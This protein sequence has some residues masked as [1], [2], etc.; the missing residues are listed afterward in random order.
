MTLKFVKGTIVELHDNYGV[1]VTSSYKHGDEYIPFEITADMTIEKEDRRFIKYTEEVEF[2]LTNSYLRGRSI[3]EGK[4]VRFV[5]SE[6]K[7]QEMNSRRDYHEVVKQVFDAYCFKVP[8]TDKESDFQNYLTMIGFQPRMLDYLLCGGIFLSRK[9][10]EQLS[11]ILTHLMDFDEFKFDPKLIVAIDRIDSEF[12]AKIVKWITSFEDAIRMYICRS[13]GP[14]SNRKT[15]EE[16]LKLL[17]SRPVTAKRVA[18]AKDKRKFRFSSNI[19]EHRNGTVVPMMDVV[20]QMNLVDLPML[21]GDLSRI[22]KELGS[23]DSLLRLIKNTSQMIRDLSVLRNAAAHCRPILSSYMDPDYNGN[24]D[25]EFDNPS[26]RAKIEKWLL[27]SSLKEMWKLR[28]DSDVVDCILSTV[29]GNPL[30]K[31]WIELN[32]LYCAVVRFSDRSLYEQFKLEVL[33]FLNYPIDGDRANNKVKL[34]H[35]RMYDMGPTT[36]EYLSGVPAPYNV[37]ANEAFDIWRI[38]DDVE[39]VD[40]ICVMLQLNEAH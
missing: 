17:Q 4:N 31:A 7:L 9:H 2:E 25:L 19:F 35:L 37:V 18:L 26:S 30:R 20:E 24:W 5:G 12:R 10:L 29:Y 21:I 27:Y 34:T 28:V 39:D 23:N 22:S 32:F 1:I 38:F 11:G 13:A 40:K 6:V 14:F 3:K 16:I 15:A 36:R 33:D 8:A